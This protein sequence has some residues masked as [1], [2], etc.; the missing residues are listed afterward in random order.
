LKNALHNDN[1]DKEEIK[2]YIKDCLEFNENEGTTYP[3]ILDKMKA[4]LRKY[5]S[6]KFL[7]KRNRRDH[8]LAA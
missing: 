4:V 2:K 3:N 8:T 5:H 6:S 1:L 7:H